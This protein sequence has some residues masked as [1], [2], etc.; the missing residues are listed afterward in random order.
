MIELTRF[1]TNIQML[2]QIAEAEG[3]AD[4]ARMYR[5]VLDDDLSGERARVMPKKL[6]SDEEYARIEEGLRREG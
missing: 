2:A 4:L 1:Q 3:F 5:K 6:V